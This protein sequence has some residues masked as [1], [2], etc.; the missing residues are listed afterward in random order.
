MK[1]S[2]NLREFSQCSF[3][4]E[5][6]LVH[7]TIFQIWIV[8]FFFVIYR[9]DIGVKPAGGTFVSGARDVKILF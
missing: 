4:V 7:V 6:P 1:K 5:I 9:K 3:N 8:L 2:K